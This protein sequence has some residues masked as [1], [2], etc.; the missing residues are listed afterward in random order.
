M[1]RPEHSP[2]PDSTS[3]TV[4][5]DYFALVALGTEHYMAVTWRTWQSLPL[6]E[7]HDIQKTA[8][9]MADGNLEQSAIIARSI[10][11]LQYVNQEA[12][13]ASAFGGDV[14]GLP[15]AA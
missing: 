1:I 13:S 10:L 7:R 8:S 2:N 3:E 15:P 12:Q 9:E 14:S 11:A 4:L 5:D 6:A